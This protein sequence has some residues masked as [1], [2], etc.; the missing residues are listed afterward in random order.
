MGN[1]YSNEIN[2]YLFR[3]EVFNGLF[4]FEI[5]DVFDVIGISSS[6]V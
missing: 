4:F 3:I 5:F 6:L 2:M 1:F